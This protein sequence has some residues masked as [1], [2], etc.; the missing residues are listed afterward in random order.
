MKSGVI[1][2]EIILLVLGYFCNVLRLDF[3]K[4]GNKGKK[5]WAIVGYLALTVIV[6]VGFFYVI[7]IQAN[8]L[9]LEFIMF[10][11][12]IAITGIGKRLFILEFLIMIVLGIYYRINDP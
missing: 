10:I 6:M 3:G 9:W 2:G 4:S 12:A 5:Y 7:A 8:I 1:S 11:V